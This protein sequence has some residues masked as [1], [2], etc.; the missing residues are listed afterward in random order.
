MKERVHH[1]LHYLPTRKL[2]SLKQL[3]WSELNYQR[4]NQELSWRDWPEQVK[5]DTLRALQAKTQKE[6]DAALL[7]IILDKAFKGE[8]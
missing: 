5:V 2:D 8:L 1:L 7:P 6:L 4:A 3:F